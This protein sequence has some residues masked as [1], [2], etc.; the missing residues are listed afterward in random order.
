MPKLE[1]NCTVTENKWVTPTTFILK[2]KTEPTFQFIPGQ[3]ISTIIPG[4]GP[5]GRDL[6]RAYSIAS[7]PEEKEIALCIKKVTGGPG[8]TYLSQ[9]SSGSSFK[10][11]APYGDFIYKTAED[12]IPCFI[13]TGT[14]VAPFRTILKSV[15][16]RKNPAKKAICLF[17]TTFEN[18]LLYHE[19]LA[20]IPELD[21]KV[22][23]SREEQA[24]DYFKGRVTQCLRELAPQWEIDKIDF[25]LCGNGAM[26]KEVKEILNEYEVPKTAIYQEKYY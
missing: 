19:D 16:Y 25:Y 6:R 12:R 17:G 9:L 7:T 8:S 13:A 2:F 18:E 21:L 4:A 10:G 1:L 24:H 14:G 22:C 15:Q 3:F 23:L 11:L 20:S 5:K 26:I